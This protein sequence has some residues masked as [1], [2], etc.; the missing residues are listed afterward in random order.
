[1]I[2]IYITITIIIVLIYLCYNKQ[3]MENFYT[4]NGRMAVD[5]QYFHDKLFDNVIYYPNKYADDYESGEEI[6]KLLSTGWN[7]CKTHCKGYCMEFGPT[8][9]TYCFKTRPK[10]YDL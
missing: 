3:K 7:N 9:H 5:D 1:M 2:Y 8:S 6:G 10:P 4:F